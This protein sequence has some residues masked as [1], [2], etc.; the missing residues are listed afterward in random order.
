MI[1]SSIYMNK[2]MFVILYRIMFLCSLL[3]ILFDSVFDLLNIHLF[4]DASN[5]VSIE[6]VS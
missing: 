5:L 4:H 6:V 2:V 1:S 3:C